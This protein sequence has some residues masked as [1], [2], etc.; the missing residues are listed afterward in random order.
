MPFAYPGPDH[1]AGAGP[2]CVGRATRHVV[3][4]PS[5][6]ELCVLNPLVRART[7]EEVETL[8]QELE[9]CGYFWD[10]VAIKYI[11]AFT[12]R[13]VRT[14]GLDSLAARPGTVTADHLDQLAAI[15]EDPLREHRKG[16]ATARYQRGGCAL[17]W[18]LILDV[19]GGWLVLPIWMWLASIGVLFVI[20]CSW[21]QWLHRK[22]HAPEIARDLGANKPDGDASG[23]TSASG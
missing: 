4:H 15:A 7:R 6:D 11:N 10:P 2:N 21:A 3:L 20:L 18:V 19:L 17:F 14:M 8:Q 16:L 5:Y 23:T 13:S 12:G 22:Y 1:V 9:Q